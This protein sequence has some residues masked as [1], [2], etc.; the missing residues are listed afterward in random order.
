MTG[1]NTVISEAFKRFYEDT[2]KPRTYQ[3]LC[4]WCE[5][6]I[7][8]AV[9]YRRGAKDAHNFT[10]NLINSIVVVL[11][12]GN[13]RAEFFS[14][15]V[16]R[17]PAIRKEMSALNSKGR[18]RRYRIHLNPDWEGHRSSYLPEVPTDGS[19]GEIDAAHFA[20]RYRP[21]VKAE[22]AIVVAYTSEYA[23]WVEF[24][25]HTTGYFAM[26]KHTEDTAV[27]LVKLK[28]KN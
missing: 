5:N 1:N 17:K 4:S 6:L 12:E 13:K 9:Q 24:Q 18:K 2:V 8:A 20:S 3:R 14:N 23:A 27:S 28:R 25:R 11:Y 16:V 7:N 15:S 21:K 22:Y 10:G 26:L 19:W